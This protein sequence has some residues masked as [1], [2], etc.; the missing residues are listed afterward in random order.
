VLA[1]PDLDPDAGGQAVLWSPGSDARLVRT[2][3]PFL[4]ALSRHADLAL[5]GV[6]LLRI[7]HTDGAWHLDHL[8]R[9]PH[10]TLGA[11]MLQDTT[12]VLRHRDVLEWPG[13][14]P[15]VFELR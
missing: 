9:G 10:V 1:V 3:R 12:H 14:A 15:L 4:I 11:R 2:G 6:P 7:R 13:A 8:D 5:P